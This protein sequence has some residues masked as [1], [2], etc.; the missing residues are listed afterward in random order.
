MPAPTCSVTQAK[1]TP[2]CVS[3]A[4][5]VSSKCKPAVGAATEVVTVYEAGLEGGS[6]AGEKD[7]PTM[8]GGSL[9]I[10]APDG[11]ASIVIGGVVALQPQLLQGMR[12]LAQPLALG[13]MNGMQ[14]AMATGT[15][16]LQIL[17][18]A[19]LRLDVAPG[20]RSLQRLLHPRAL[21]GR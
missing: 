16:G 7:A 18:I 21:Q 9:S 8:A 1:L 5:K 2:C 6:Q 4:S 10:N 11:V 20:Q 13:G 15:Q 12:G 19:L 3:V 17:G 14:A